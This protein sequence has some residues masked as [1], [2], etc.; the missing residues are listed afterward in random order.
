MVDIIKVRYHKDP[1]PCYHVT[2]CSACNEQSNLISQLTKIT[3]C[4]IHPAPVRITT[5]HSQSVAATV[6]LQLVLPA[7]DIEA[8]KKRL[9]A[10]HG[11]LLTQ[12][13]ALT[14]KLSND[15]FIAKAP[16]QVVQKVERDFNNIVSEL[17]AIEQQI[18]TLN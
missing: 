10:Q 3:D 12:K 9:A 1:P 18:A 13:D 15:Q 5:P 17:T 8:E 7:I 14:K 4:H 16:P 2:V 11:Q 6:E